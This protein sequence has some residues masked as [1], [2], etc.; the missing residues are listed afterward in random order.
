MDEQA[1]FLG[2]DGELAVVLVDAQPADR[3]DPVTQTADVAAARRLVGQR[4]VVAAEFERV[5][6]RLGAA[7]RHRHSVVSEWSV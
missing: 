2:P 6:R 5:L 7:S 3:L 4:S 1:V